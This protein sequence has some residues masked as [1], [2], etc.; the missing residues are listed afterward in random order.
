MTVSEDQ[1]GPGYKPALTERPL[2]DALRRRWSP[3]ALDPTRRVDDETI[4]TLLDAARWAPSSRNEQPW[5]YLVFDGSD[6]N[7]RANAEACLYPGNAWAKRAP[8]LMLSVAKRTHSNLDRRNPMALHD[9]GMADLSV[10]L[11]AVSM[12]L[13]AHQMRGFDRDKARELFAIPDDFNPVV[14]IAVGYY[15]DPDALED[16][17]ARDD[18][19]APRERRPLSEIAFGGTWGK[20]FA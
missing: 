17:K 6:A 7:A 15:G 18:E 11:Q 14:M 13:V 10:V 8:L 2:L 16:P 5:R 3:R 1:P 4:L 12:G 19:A 9:T 20:P